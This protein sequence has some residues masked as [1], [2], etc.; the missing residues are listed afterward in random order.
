[1]TPVPNGQLVPTTEGL[2]L[3]IVRTFNAPIEDVWASRTESE[4]TARWIG[5]WIGERRVVGTVYVQ[6]TEEEDAC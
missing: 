2:D 5:T 6:M 1:M 3:V 4:R